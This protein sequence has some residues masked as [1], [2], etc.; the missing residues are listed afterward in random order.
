MELPGLDDGYIAGLFDGEGSVSI[1][2]RR[3]KGEKVKNG[4]PGKT[5][6]G[7]ALVIQITNGYKPILD[8][9]RAIYGGRVYKQSVYKGSRPCW[10]W[11]LRAQ[12]SR[13]FLTMVQHYIHIKR[14]QVQLALE[15]IDLPYGSTEERQGYYEAMSA[16]NGLRTH[17]KLVTVTDEGVA[18]E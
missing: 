17:H 6:I 9:V 16:L 5:Y 8:A 2:I 11:N 10:V 4:T 15:F 1:G 12:A 3:T 14:A 13:V 18:V 7:Y